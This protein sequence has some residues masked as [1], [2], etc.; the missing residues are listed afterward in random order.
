MK[1]TV[2]NLY[3]FFFFYKKKKKK[4]FKMT[5]IKYKQI[6]GQG[7]IQVSLVC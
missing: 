3:L 2:V 5:D 6:Y 4:K 7:V 1:L